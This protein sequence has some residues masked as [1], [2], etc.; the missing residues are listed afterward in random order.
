MLPARMISDAFA[1]QSVTLIVLGVGLLAA[2][3]LPLFF[4]PLRWARVWQWTIPDD[5]ALT[6]YLGRCVGALAIAIVYAFFRAAGDP[7]AYLILYEIM[8]IAAALLTAIHAWGAITRSQP[9][10]ETWEIGLYGV[11]TVVSI[12]LRVSVPGTAG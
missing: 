4:A 12:W 7:P 6:V 5:S 11:L 10:T 1:I 8:I 9:W 3:G 2:F